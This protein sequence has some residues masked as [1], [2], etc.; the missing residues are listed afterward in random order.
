MAAPLLISCRRTSALRIFKVIFRIRHQRLSSQNEFLTE[1]LLTVHT[2]SDSHLIPLLLQVC[3]NGENHS[4]KDIIQSESDIHFGGGSFPD[5]LG[6]RHCQKNI[7]PDCH[8]WP[9]P[10]AESCGGLLLYKFWRIL[11]GIFL[12]DCSVGFFH[13]NE[14]K[15]SGD[16]IS[17][18]IRRLKKSPRNIRSLPKTDPNYFIRCHS[19]TLQGQKTKGTLRF[20]R[21]PEIGWA[22]WALPVL[23]GILGVSL[24]ITSKK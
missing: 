16:K 4:Q 14:E 19:T 1:C 21:N 11:L 22:A 7:C 5:N 13:Q 17:E 2:V 15:E 12:D 10:S 6:S 9:G 20:K 3:I 8:F 18:E 24:I 23:Q